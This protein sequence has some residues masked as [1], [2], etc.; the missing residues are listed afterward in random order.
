MSITK[1][2]IRPRSQNE[3][4]PIAVERETEYFVY[5]KYGTRERRE[6]KVTDFY[7]ICDSWEQARDV[8]LDH[9]KREADIAWS[10]CTAG[11]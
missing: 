2:K 9:V 5:V 10:R 7:R 6:A 11:A 3:I 4:E 8:L 1:F